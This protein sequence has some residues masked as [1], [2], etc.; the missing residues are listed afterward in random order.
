M[1]KVPC[2]LCYIKSEAVD[3]KAI[4]NICDTC[5]QQN[6]HNILKN[7]NYKMIKDALDKS[8]NK[9]SITKDGE[10]I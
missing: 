8:K 5:M 9:P 4:A 7:V 10:V 2:I 6:L 3:E 1:P